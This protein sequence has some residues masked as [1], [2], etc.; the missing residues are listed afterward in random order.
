MAR[1][2]GKQ[3][4]NITAMEEK[5]G[6]NIDVQPLGAEKQEAGKA[7]EFGS[8][9]TKNSVQ[10]FV[11]EKYANRNFDIFIDGDYL[12]TAKASKKAVIKIKKAN[13]MAKVLVDALNSG[14][15]IALMPK[16]I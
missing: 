7:V 9:I 15:E 14:A 5:I 16:N 4:S 2:I 12:I 3:G 13:K 1:V 6:I 11:E 10:L 8:K